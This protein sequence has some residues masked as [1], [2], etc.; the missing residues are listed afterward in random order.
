MGKWPRV[1]LTAGLVVLADQATKLAVLRWLAPVGRVEVVPGFFDLTHLMNTGVAFG[2]LAGRSGLWRAAGLSLMALVALG[3]VASFIARTR[4]EERVFLWGLALVAGG[5]V[6]NLIDR[7][8]LGAVVDFLDLYVGTWHWPAFN[9][10]DA[11]IT[12][13]TGLILLHLW[14]TRHQGDSAGD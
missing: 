8:R 9:V 4:P 6:G 3:I 5:A 10:A 1:G 14:L 12:I 2:V 13:G 7:I 11:G